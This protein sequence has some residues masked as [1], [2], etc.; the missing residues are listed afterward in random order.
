VCSLFGTTLSATGPGDCWV[1]ATIAADS[2]YSLATSA[3]VEVVFTNVVPVV[4]AVSPDSGPASAGQPIT[5]TGTG[6][7]PDSTVV[8]GQGH[9]AGTGTVP[10]TGVT[11]VSPTELTAVTP[12][13]GKTG[14]HHVFVT[15]AGGTSAPSRANLYDF[16]PVVTSVTPHTG[17][18]VGGE[19]ITIKGMDFAPDSSVVI[20]QG[21]GPVTGALAASDVHYVSSTEITAVT[22]GGAKAGTFSLYVVSATAGTSPRSRAS[23]YVYYAAPV[24][25][26]VS[27]GSG[28][29]SG[30]TTVTIT[31]K[32]FVPG[33]TVVIGQGD[34]SG[35]GAVAATAVTYVSPNE[36]TAVT[37]VGTK[38]GTWH[39]FV[40]SPA[41]TSGYSRAATFTY[42]G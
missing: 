17:P 41:G 34:K 11:Y 7:L 5:I 33:S 14:L 31:G 27:P 24:V 10:A 21:H 26:A 39:L 32:N 6:F 28:P 4:T 18:V 20:G 35:T 19:P 23:A 3:D 8:I 1:Y 37:G 22:P 40:T 12:V 9:G 25:S 29:L 42:S 15:T 36:L 30:G 16:L 13:G 2:T 38:A